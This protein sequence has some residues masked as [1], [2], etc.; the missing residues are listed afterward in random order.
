MD[1]EPLF[2][3]SLGMNNPLPAPIPYGSAGDLP[4][5][6]EMRDQL[7]GLK[8]LTLFVSRQQRSH[9]V[10]LETQLNKMVRIVDDFYALLGPRHWVFPSNQSV[11]HIEGLI[12]ADAEDAERQLIALYT[13]DRLRQLIWQLNRHPEMQIRLDLVRFALEDFEARRYYATVLV[14]LAVMDGFVNDIDRDHRRGLHARMSTEMVAWDSVTGHHMGLAHAHTVF[15][16]GSTK[17]TTTELTELRRNG[18]VHGSELN[19]NNIVVA[20]KAWNQLFAVADWATSLQRQAVP[21]PPKPTWRGIANQIKTNA[22]NRVALDAWQPS[23]LNLNDAGFATHVV[24]VATNNFLQ[25]WRS[26]NY[27]AMAALVSS[28]VAEE[29]V[30]K[31]AG[32]VRGEYERSVLDAYEILEVDHLACAACEVDVAITI[33]GSARLGRMRWIREASDGATAM[34]TDSGEWK[35]IIWGPLAILNR[36]Q[37][38]HGT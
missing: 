15:R 27:G 16:S 14:L 20:T 33:D 9:L 24:A 22:A 32:M 10:E 21:T 38:E 30:S 31:T 19:F 28:M 36:W 3:Y 1:N 29:S 26:R 8:A 4:S 23:R 12:S 37:S 34:P 2:V 35:L 18:I 13:P 5:I 25:A 11:D 17:T 6:V 7:R